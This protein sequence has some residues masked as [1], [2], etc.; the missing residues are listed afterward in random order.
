MS[1]NRAEYRGK[2]FRS[3]NSVALR[4]PKALGVSEG[5]EMQIVQE[6][7]MSF[8]ME[9]IGAPKRRIDISKFVGKA[10]WLKPIPR[11]DF[12]DRPSGWRMPDWGDAA[13]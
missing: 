7:P 9:A 4:L 2:V 6:A 10:P 1:D 13:E 3:G 11:E 12:E 5:T 8:R